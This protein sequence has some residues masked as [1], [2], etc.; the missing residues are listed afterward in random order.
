MQETGRKRQ[1]NGGVYVA[2]V[3]YLE[4]VCSLKF[5]GVVMKP[6]HLL[7]CGG[8]IQIGS[9]TKKELDIMDRKTEKEKRLAPTMVRPDC[10]ISF[11]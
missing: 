10:N 11:Y 9:G 4:T 6:E 7:W 5:G 8:L 1:S 3:W 2:I